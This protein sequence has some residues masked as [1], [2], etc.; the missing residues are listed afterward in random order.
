M[1]LQF[2]INRHHAR[3]LGNDHEKCLEPNACVKPLRA[4]LRC[5]KKGSHAPCRKRVARAP[6]A[7]YWMEERQAEKETA[8][9]AAQG[10]P[11]RVAP[12]QSWEKEWGAQRR[13]LQTP[14]YA[15]DNNWWTR[16]QVAEMVPAPP[17]HKTMQANGGGGAGQQ[18]KPSEVPLEVLVDSRRCLGPLLKPSQGKPNRGPRRT[19]LERK[20]FAGVLTGVR[21]SA[22]PLRPMCG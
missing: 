10:P 15:E 9:G 2:Q 5:S 7:D 16:E 18:G 1:R 8:N 11:F 3:G 20:S 19:S 21:P 14:I 22:N 13:P 12:W 17:R 4:L 6:C